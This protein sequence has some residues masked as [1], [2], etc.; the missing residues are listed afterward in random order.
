MSKLGRALQRSI[1]S[2]QSAEY[3]KLTG[4]R[5][6][7]YELSELKYAALDTLLYSW[8]SPIV[9]FAEACK[10]TIKW[11]PIIWKDR[12]WDSHYILEIL[13]CKLRF[14][15]EYLQ[16]FGH[17]T[18]VSRDCKNIRIAEIL[19]ERIQKDNYHEFLMGEHEEKWGKLI[20]G[21]RKDN[22]LFDNKFS[23]S[24]LRRSKVQSQNDFEQE[25]KEARAIHQYHNHMGKQDRD[26]LFSHMRKH[27]DQW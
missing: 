15:R 21:D 22:I 1:R 26:F 23:G 19:I 8:L 24:G 14:S 16:Q 27:I 6:W 25:R 3:T 11:L 4:K 18:N 5:D 17:H 20:F 7:K 2:I 13:K 12:E 9:V 10:R